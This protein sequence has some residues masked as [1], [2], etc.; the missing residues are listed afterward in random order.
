MIHRKK[1]VD[2]LPTLPN[3]SDGPIMGPNL[4]AADALSGNRAP[5]GGGSCIADNIL[6][7]GEG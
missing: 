4:R 6:L 7:V 1:A 2:K 3:P 5:L